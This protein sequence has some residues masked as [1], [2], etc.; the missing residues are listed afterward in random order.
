MGLHGQDP[1]HR[2]QRE[3]AET[4][5]P[6]ERRAQV[7]AAI[8]PQAGQDLASLFPATPLPAEQT[9]Q[10]RDRRLAQFLELLSSQFA[11]RFAL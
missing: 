1:F 3:R 11:T 8:V 6:F 7:F 2:A 10:E 5:G 9:F 4:V